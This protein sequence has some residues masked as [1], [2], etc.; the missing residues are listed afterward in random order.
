MPDVLFRDAGNAHGRLA[1]LSLRSLAARLDTDLDHLQITLNYERNARN[2]V[3]PL[4]EVVAAERLLRAVPFEMLC[5][6][7]VCL[8]RWQVIVLADIAAGACNGL[9]LLT[10]CALS[11][12]RAERQQHMPA[13]AQFDKWCATFRGLGA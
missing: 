12:C 7:A 10:S 13:P 11:S 3:L 5:W 2:P 4:K 8:A 9:L 1:A 6:C